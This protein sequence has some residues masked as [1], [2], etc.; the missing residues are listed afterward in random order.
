[1]AQSVNCYVKKKKFA[2]QAQPLFRFYFQF[3]QD[4]EPDMSEAD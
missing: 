1:M 3:I 4:P 2:I